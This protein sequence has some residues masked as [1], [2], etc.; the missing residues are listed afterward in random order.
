M[1]NSLGQFMRLNFANEQGLSRPLSEDEL[2]QLKCIAARTGALLIWI[3]KDLTCHV[4]STRLS[5]PA[6]F[7]REG[8]RHVHS[9]VAN[10]V[11]Y[12]RRGDAGRSS[13]C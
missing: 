5:P 6:R 10:D 9:D 1:E 4:V 2:A 8:V 12:V 11:F 3:D 7:R 13:R